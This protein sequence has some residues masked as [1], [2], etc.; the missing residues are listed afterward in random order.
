MKGKKIFS[1]LE[2]LELVARRIDESG[3]DITREYQNWINV[4]FACASLGEE[5]RES[6]HTICRQYA[7]YKRE[8]C[9]ERFD[10]CMRTG[11]GDIT[12]G[13]IIKLAKDRGVDT[14][15]PRGPR[16]KTQEQRKEERENRFQLMR[17]KINEWYD[18]R[19]D[20]WKHRVEIAPCGT[21]VWQPL[22]DRDLSTI[23]TR[24]QEQGI[25]TKQNDVKALLESRDFSTDFDAVYKW[26]K[27]LKPYDPLN[28][29]DYL[30]EFFNGH[31]SYDDAENADFYQQMLQKWFVGMVALW[32]GRAEENP[33]MPVFCGPQHIGKTY[34][35]RNLLP[36]QLRQYTKEPNPRDPVDK[37]FIISLSEVVL[38]FLDE[39]SISSNMKS[40]TYKAIIT[41][42][43]SNLRDAYARYREVRKR[44]ASLI[45]ATNYQQF[46]RDSEGNRRYIGI[47]LKSTA[48]LNQHPLPYEGA[49]AQ[50]LWLLENGYDP[51]PS[52]EDS[53]H[54]SRHN[55]DFMEADDCEEALGVFL[56]QPTDD[57]KPEAYSAGELMQE[58][59]L[60]GFRSNSFKANNIGKA[61]HRMGFRSKK[62][63]GNNKY[64]VVIVDD[65]SQKENRKI[66]G[67]AADDRP[68]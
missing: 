25:R 3:A 48:D 7:K 45:G 8:E 6:Y 14:S 28:D 5:A 62:I 63:R 44:K 10:N 13:T 1:D 43:Q 29:P 53:D 47:A 34:F 51:K 19:F 49:Y 41:S 16:P 67:A 64:L 2:H 20:V 52:R 12:L 18:I 31:L 33:L 40:D 27:T 55:R 39:F 36:P 35:I 17:Q 61:M 59:N 42:N 22:N 9:D 54:I 46:I 65:N 60:R 37:D 26:L 15:L 68:F 30:D 56:R 4:T 23:Y 57:E 50:A 32:T 24:L 66:G 58:L 21:G 11:R 38:I